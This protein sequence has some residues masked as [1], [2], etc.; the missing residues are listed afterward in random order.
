M[1]AF[2]QHAGSATPKSYRERVSDGE[3]GVK[4]LERPFTQRID[5]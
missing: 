2:V 3:S 4:S 1:E 5:I